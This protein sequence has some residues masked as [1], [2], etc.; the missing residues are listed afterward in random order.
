MPPNDMP[1]KRQKQITNGKN[2]DLELIPAN[3]I[4]TRYESLENFLTKGLWK[5]DEYNVL[6]GVRIDKILI[7]KVIYKKKL[8]T[9][10]FF[11]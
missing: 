4:I 8:L 3:F 9:K 11:S 6:D 10:Q 5:D 7:R 1:M 2:F